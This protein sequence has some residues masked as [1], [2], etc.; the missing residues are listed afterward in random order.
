MKKAGF[1]VTLVVVSSTLF[2]GSQVF[3][4]N[5]PAVHA[6]AGSQPANSQSD[7]NIRAAVVNDLKSSDYKD[8][9]VTVHGGV[10]DLEGTVKD[11]ATKEQADKKVHRIKNVEAVRNMI[12]I[13]S[14]GSI[15]DAELQ[16]KLVTAIEYNRVGYW[17]QSPTIK[18]VTPFNAISVSVNNGVVTLGG[19]AADPVSADSAVALT[20]RTPGV[21]DVIDNIKVNPTSIM[22]DRLR[23]Q[24]YRAI[25]GYPALN[26]Y[27]I[28]PGQPIRI[29]V[30]NGH[31]I[32][33]GVVINQMDKNIAGIQANGV[34]GVFSVTNNLQVQGATK[35]RK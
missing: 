33:S 25:Y 14:A 7:N 24:L 26:K 13:P 15:S 35:E 2:L 32:L 8:V 22:D 6:Q 19:H 34:P 23:L 17:G 28:D 9:R 18:N 5:A 27:A 3:L 10:V 1:G 12:R 16:K 29:T 31:V 21:R 20:S 4:S 11:Y 30:D